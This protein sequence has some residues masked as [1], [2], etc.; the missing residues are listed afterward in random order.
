MPHVTTIL[1]NEV[2]IQYQGTRDASSLMGA[3]QVSGLIVGQFKRGRL[4]QPM[5]ITLENVKGTLGEDLDNPDYLAVLD[6]LASGVPSVQVM[7]VGESGSGAGGDGGAGGEQQEPLWDIKYKVNGQWVY[8]VTGQVVEVSDSRNSQ[9][10]QLATELV[11]SDRVTEIGYLAFRYWDA[12]VSVDL[13]NTVRS[14]SNYAFES[15]TSLKNIVFSNSLEVIGYSALL[16]CINLEVLDFGENLQTIKNAALIN[17]YRLHTIVFR[18][19]PPVTF[20]G[21]PFGNGGSGDT[22]PQYVYVPDH[23]LDEYYQVLEHMLLNVRHYG[24]CK[25]LSQYNG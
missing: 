1:G 6:A 9:Y 16:G 3:A 22:N 23:L 21:N 24:A 18:S 7:R 10:R 12:L 19:S 8:E 2:G 17:L 20:E 15:C 14:I 13:G 11:V 4:D 5:T 25:P